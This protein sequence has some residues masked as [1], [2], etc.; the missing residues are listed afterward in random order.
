[1]SAA[2][3]VTGAAAFGKGLRDTADKLHREMESLLKKEARALCVSLS[4]Q[5]LPYGFNPPTEKQQGR[6]KAEI[7]RVYLNSRQTSAIMDLIKPRSQ[8]LAWGFWHAMKNGDEARARRYMRQAGINVENLDPSQ[9]RA[10]RTGPRG[11]VAKSAQPAQV[12]K[13]SS[14]AKFTR[15]KQATIGTAKAGW[16]A[17]A[18]ALGGRVRTNTTDASGNRSTTETIPPYI[19]KLTTKFAGLGGARIMPGRVE[20]FTNVTYADEALPQGALESAIDT[21]AT[22][23]RDSITKAL[24]IILRRSLS[25]AA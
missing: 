8:R 9:H 14:L 20:I 6:I 22:S 4:F 13:D 19:R 16:Y 12:V 23:F 15:E 10:A 11:S 1:M 24:A 17:A 5:T 7:G 2:I 18:K 25:R 3:K 21:A